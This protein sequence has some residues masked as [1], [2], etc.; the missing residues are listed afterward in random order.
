MSHTRRIHAFALW[1]ACLT[2]FSGCAGGEAERRTPPPG[3][4]PLEQTGP[5]ERRVAAEVREQNLIFSDEPAARDYLRRKLIGL[6]VQELVEL[7]FDAARATSLASEGR[8]QAFTVE[9]REAKVHGEGAEAGLIKQVKLWRVEGRLVVLLS[10]ELAAELVE[11]LTRLPLVSMEEVEAVQGHLAKLAARKPDPALLSALER[12]VGDRWAELLRPFMKAQLDTPLQPAAGF[13]DALERVAVVLRVFREAQPEHPAFGE[14]EKDFILGCLRLQ[15]AIPVGETGAAALADM[16]ARVQ[17][18]AA[19]FMPQIMP[20]L[21]RDLELAWRD[22]L[23]RLDDQ[24]MAFPGLKGDFLRFLETFPSSQFYPD[25]E[26]RFLLRWAEHLQTPRPPGLESLEGLVREVELLG[27]RFPSFQRLPEL[28]AHLGQRCLESLSR[29]SAPDLQVM[30]RI[31]ATLGA[32]DAFLPAGQATM[33]MRARLDKQERELL[34]RRDDELERVALRE[35]TFFID[36]DRAVG[37]LVWGA[38]RAAWQGKGEF[39][40]RWETGKDAGEQCRCSLDPEE[41]CRVFSAEGA[42]GGFEVV[43]RFHRD[44]LAGVDLCDVYVGPQLP[45]IY[46]FFAR[47]YEAE[48][49]DAEGATFLAGGGGPHSRGVRFARPPEVLVELERSVDSCTVRYRSA[50]VQGE[51]D[52]DRKAEREAQARAKLQARAERLRR[53]WEVG[54]CV[55]WAC[56]PQCDYTGRVRARRGETYRVSITRSETDRREEGSERSV[57]AEELFDCP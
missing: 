40:R 50:S 33:D 31:Q 21:L 37:G 42:A 5:A 19:D 28:Q 45:N 12:K 55:R 26:L 11:R 23:I 34:R 51:I 7:G 57:P 9:G 30:R 46:R 18:S 15:R 4:A 8:L 43:A 36:W 27:Q 54:A 2:A 56:A 38:K 47:R 32:C 16:H 17:R 10:D 52:G 6:L 1:A 14:L 3:E 53:G 25:L 24:R 35:L 39:A 20:Y 49:G 29:L 22:H 44:R 48:H 41:P 13:L